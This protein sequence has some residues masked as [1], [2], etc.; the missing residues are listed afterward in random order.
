MNHTSTDSESEI[1]H[2]ALEDTSSTPIEPTIKQFQ[3]NSRRAASESV[4]SD[5]VS[6]GVALILVHVG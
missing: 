3:Q 4:A 6:D 2:K 5:F 1:Y